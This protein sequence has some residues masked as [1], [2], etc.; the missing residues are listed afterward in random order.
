MLMQ[1]AIQADKFFALPHQRVL[2]QPVEED[3]VPGGLFDL[4]NVRPIAAAAEHRHT[5]GQVHAPPVEILERHGPFGHAAVG[6]EANDE[7]H[8]GHAPYRRDRTGLVG[9]WTPLDSGPGRVLTDNKP[10][11]FPPLNG[12]LP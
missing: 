4:Q 7:V 6:T 1:E 12:P 5:V 8:R 3:Q 2:A 11:N 10:F 9:G